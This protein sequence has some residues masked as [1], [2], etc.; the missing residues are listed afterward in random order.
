MIY[1]VDRLQPNCRGRFRSPAYLQVS[2]YKYGRGKKCGFATVNQLNELGVKYDTV[3]GVNQV[4]F[5]AYIGGYCHLIEASMVLCFTQKWS[6]EIEPAIC[7]WEIHF[8]FSGI[9]TVQVVLRIKK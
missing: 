9:E 6:N 5:T 2:G 8:S 3:V 1:T 4:W 7:N